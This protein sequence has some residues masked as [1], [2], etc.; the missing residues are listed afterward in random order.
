MDIKD[1]LV[2]KIL[3]KSDLNHIYYLALEQ[4]VETATVQQIKEYCL[5]NDGVVF[6]N[7]E[8]FNQFYQEFIEKMQPDLFCLNKDLMMALYLADLNGIRKGLTKELGLNFE[9]PK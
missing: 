5:L 6:Y 2:R 1:E 8:E 7:D 4:W 9:F 3:L